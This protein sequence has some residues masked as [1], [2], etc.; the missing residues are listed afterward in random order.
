MKYENNFISQKKIRELYKD[1]RNE[2]RERFYFTNPMSRK[3]L[4]FS[5][6]IHVFTETF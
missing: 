1:I 3:C 6:F 2:I 5:F 4:L